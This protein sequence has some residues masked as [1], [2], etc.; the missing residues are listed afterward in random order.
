MH[1]RRIAHRD[2]KLENIMVE[3]R[4]ASAVVRFGGFPTIKVIDFG[5]SKRLAPPAE[6]VDAH[7]LAAPGE[8]AA[9]AALL[10]QLD[11][12]QPAARGVRHDVART[13]RGVP[14]FFTTVGA[15]AY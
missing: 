9:A 2:L 7:S 15:C 11:S 3:N 14:R 13:L 12:Q 5:L 4:A 10:A 1:E 6:L 8:D